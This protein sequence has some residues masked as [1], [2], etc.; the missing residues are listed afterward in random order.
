LQQH[1]HWRRHARH[2]SLLESRTIAIMAA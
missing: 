1:W 2:A